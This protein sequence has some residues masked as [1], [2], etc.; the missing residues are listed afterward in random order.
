MEHTTGR[1]KK[2]RR[3]SSD[4]GLIME[5]RKFVM[6]PW[7]RYK[8]LIRSFRDDLKVEGHHLFG[9]PLELQTRAGI[10]GTFFCFSIFSRICC[11]NNMKQNSWPETLVTLGPYFISRCFSFDKCILSLII[12]LSLLWFRQEAAGALWNLSFDDR[13][14]EAIAAA[15]GVE[16][17]VWC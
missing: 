8:W 14:R 7:P 4:L 13:N 16:A 5:V 17:L 1:E 10:H 12:V 9:W 11:I 6:N 3:K 2:G 15:G